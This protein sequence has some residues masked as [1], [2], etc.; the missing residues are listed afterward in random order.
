[1]KTFTKHTM[2]ILSMLVLAG[3]VLFGGMTGNVQAGDKKVYSAT[4]CRP[5][6]GNAIKDLPFRYDTGRI[7]N[8]S[9]TAS[10]KIECPVVRDN[11]DNVNG[12]KAFGFVGQNLNKDGRFKCVM[13]SRD[14]E[15]GK[16]LDSAGWYIPY[17]K[18]LPVSQRFNKKPRK[19][20][21]SG[22][23]FYRLQCD[24]PKRLPGRHSSYLSSYWVEEWNSNPRIR[25]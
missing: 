23:S 21:R 4:M 15:T 1:M 5:V 10:L 17:N 25:Y 13:S 9:L 2:N 3:G 18:S 19:S 12:L 24:I 16:H 20:Q 14:F 6:W 7:R 8:H 22:K 11:H